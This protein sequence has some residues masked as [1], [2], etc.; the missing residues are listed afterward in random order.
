[1][2]PASTS[3]LTPALSPGRGR[4]ICCAPYL[5]IRRFFVCLFECLTLKSK[6]SADAARIGELSNAVPLPSLSLGER[7][8]VRAGVTTI[9]HHFS[10]MHGIPSS[11]MLLSANL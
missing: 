2:D 5:E 9:I 8:G 11:G 6:E 1:L 3:A 7:A 4:I 10:M